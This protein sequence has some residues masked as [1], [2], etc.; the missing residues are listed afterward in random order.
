[1]QKKPINAPIFS[2]API[3]PDLFAPFSSDLSDPLVPFFL[4]SEL[5]YF[6]FVQVAKS[7]NKKVGG[8]PYR[9]SPSIRVEKGAAS[10]GARRGCF[11]V[12][13][14]ISRLSFSANF[15]MYLAA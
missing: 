5:L 11:G 8:E 7:T 2:D 12:T 10:A 15:P 3:S 14:G 9:G 13:P 6:L 4:P 1:M